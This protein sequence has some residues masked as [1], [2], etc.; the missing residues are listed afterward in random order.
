[1]SWS[2]RDLPNPSFEHALDDWITSEP[3]YYRDEEDEDY[4]DEEWDD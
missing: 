1:M 2:L 4:D 3:E